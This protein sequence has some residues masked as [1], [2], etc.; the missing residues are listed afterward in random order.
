MVI[1][2]LIMVTYNCSE[3]ENWHSFED[4]PIKTNALYKG[5]MI[6]ITEGHNPI[7][8]VLYA[9]YNVKGDN[10]YTYVSLFLQKDFP[11]K[12]FEVITQK[13][14]YKGRSERTYRYIP[15]KYQG[16]YDLFMGIIE[17]RKQE[18][19]NFVCGIVTMKNEV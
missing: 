1:G 17:K 3:E 12:I 14:K 8:W 15:D 7:K 11:F 5:E 10:E 16:I 6:E 18:N 19:P 13:P 2:D 9:K 4:I